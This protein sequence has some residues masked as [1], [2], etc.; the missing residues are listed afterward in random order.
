MLLKD[1]I[2]TFLVH[3]KICF[4]FAKVNAGQHMLCLLSEELHTHICP[5]GEISSSYELAGAR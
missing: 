1:R 3:A 2:H 5:Q 4:I